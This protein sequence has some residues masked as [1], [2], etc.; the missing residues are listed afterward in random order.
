MPAAR[1][2]AAR[3][4]PTDNMDEASAT[5]LPTPGPDREMDEDRADDVRPSDGL[6]AAGTGVG[7]SAPA[8]AP[9]ADR[10]E[11]VPPDGAA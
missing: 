5:S 7:P 4:Y 6:P 11:F 10:G 1:D 2:D 8:P 3:S 9:Y